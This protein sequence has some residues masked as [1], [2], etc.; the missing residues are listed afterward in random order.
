M[1]SQISQRVLRLKVTASAA[2]NEALRPVPA[3]PLYICAVFPPVWMFVSALNGKLG[4]D[5][6][7]ALEH[8]MGE[9]GLQV[10]LATL[11]VS[12]LRRFTGVNLIKFRRA[13]GLIGFFYIFAHLLVWLIL[14]VQIP[15]E[16]IKDILKRPYI[17]IGMIAFILMVPLA[18]TSNNWSMRKLR[19]NWRK[20]HRLSYLIIILGGL[21]FVMLRKGIQLEPVLYLLAGVILVGMRANPKKKT[22]RL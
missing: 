12:P 21:H 13:M 6:V 8:E 10:L 14:D 18:I 1:L 4:I 9:L 15:S 16:I 19:A 7:K 11:A 17:S 2:V 20:L 22:T 3:W 5:P